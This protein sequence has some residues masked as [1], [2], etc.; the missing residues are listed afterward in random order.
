MRRHFDQEV[1][2]L[3]CEIRRYSTGG[4]QVLWPGH[5]AQEQDIWFTC[6]LRHS[7]SFVLTTFLR[8]TPATPISP[9]EDHSKSFAIGDKDSIITTGNADWKRHTGSESKPETLV[10]M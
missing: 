2:A 10:H 7:G 4:I 5:G 9:Q 3:H 1:E 6:T 8:H